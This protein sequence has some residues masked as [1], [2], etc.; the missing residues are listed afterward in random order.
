MNK[1]LLISGVIALSLVSL[2]ASESRSDQPLELRL[3]LTEGDSYECVMVLTR[4]MTQNIDGDEQKLNQELS[5]S[6]NYEISG[7]TDDG[8][9][10]LK[11]TYKRIRIKQDF[12]FSQSEY[13]SDNPPS[14]IEPS[15]KGYVTLIGSVL[16]V[17][18]NDKGDVVRLSGAEDLI[19]RMVAEIDLPD[20]PMK[21]QMISGIRSQFGEVALRESL[22]QITSF[23]PATH[24][25]AGDQWSSE[26]SLYTGFPMRI[27]SRYTLISRDDGLAEIKVESEIAAGDD[28][29]GIEMGPVNIFYD[30]AG[31]QNGIIEVDETSGLPVKSE[32]EMGF[33]GTVNVSGLPGGESRSW[34]IKA[35]GRVAVTFEKK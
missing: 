30:I 4:D 27:L 21:D 28:S 16:E 19:D 14:Y 17:S 29:S 20:S 35:D 34:P 2:F 31:T 7:V 9:I 23:Y 24:V 11:M 26:K 10:D 25:S 15:M 18:L 5:I 8:I 12:G 3:I 6:W 22:Q 13:D 33:E 1:F 32:M